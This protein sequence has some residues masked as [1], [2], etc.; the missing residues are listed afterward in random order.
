MGPPLST[1]A[2]TAVTIADLVTLIPYWP[3]PTGSSWALSRCCIG[4]Q[5]FRAHLPRRHRRGV[6]VLRGTSPGRIPGA[7]YDRR[8]VGLV[9]C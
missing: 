4:W 7:R 6:P 8:G 9:C 5:L 1:S 3:L 2:T